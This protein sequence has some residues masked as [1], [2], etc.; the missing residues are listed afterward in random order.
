[1][2]PSE[3]SQTTVPDVRLPWDTSE[4]LEDTCLLRSYRLP[5]IQ[6]RV[7]RCVE[8]GSLRSGS[9]CE[10]YKDVLKK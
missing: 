9:G 8:G 4:S 2:G 10:S 1:M 6:G 7:C 3:M 5:V